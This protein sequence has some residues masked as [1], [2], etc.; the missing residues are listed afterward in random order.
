MRIE[1]YNS[2][3][4]KKFLASEQYRSMPYL[5]VSEHRAQS[6]L[7]NPRLDPGDILLYVGF[8]GG[9][10]IAYRAILPDRH[11][12]VRFGWLSGIWGRIRQRGEHHSESQRKGNHHC[13]GRG[14]RY[15]LV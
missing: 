6:W 12:L 7:H 11:G 2:G 1:R 9:D 3:E 4:L 8:E 13:L 14:R 15:A 10:M 5:P